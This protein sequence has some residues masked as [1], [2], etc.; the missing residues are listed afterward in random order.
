MSRVFMMIGYPSPD[1]RNLARKLCKR[2]QPCVILSRDER[3]GRVVDL[4]DRYRNELDVGVNIVLDNTH[5][6]EK[7]RIPFLEAAQ[8]YRNVRVYGVWL[9]SS[10]YDC[11]IRMLTVY[12]RKHGVLVDKT[13]RDPPAVPPVVFFR[14]RKKLQIPQP[15]EGFSKLYRMN[16]PRPVWHQKKRA[17]FFDL[18][19]TLR[20]VRHLQRGYPRDVRD[21]RL[22]RPVDKIDKALERFP[23]DDVFVVLSNQSGVADHDV[24]LREVHDC[25]HETQQQLGWETLYVYLC[26]HTGKGPPQCY[27]RKPQLGLVVQ[28]AEELGIH[29][30]HSLFIGD[31]TTD[32]T[33]AERV[34][35]TFWKSP[36]CWD[37]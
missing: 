29:P 13:T 19:G 22:I 18:D 25:I 31:K 37:M 12:W 9:D 35:A 16:V 21:V 33:L 6:L 1:K 7:H 20:D 34:G 23:H 26:V 15:T 11:Q 36:E 3:G 4:L 14:M 24:S 32:Q 27:C 10:I 8:Q 17:V 28:A 30:R 5:L 2:Y